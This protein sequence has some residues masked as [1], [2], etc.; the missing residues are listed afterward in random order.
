MKAW[1]ARPI[2]IPAAIFLLIAA[3]WAFQAYS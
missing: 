2:V 1:F 3:A